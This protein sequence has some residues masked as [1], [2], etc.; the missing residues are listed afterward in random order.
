MGASRQEH[1]NKCCVP[2]CAA[3]TQHTLLCPR[4]SSV[5][6]RRLLQPLWS[7]PHRVLQC[8]LAPLTVGEVR[9]L[10][11]AELVAVLGLAGIHRL[12]IPVPTKEENGPRLKQWERDRRGGMC[13]GWRHVYSTGRLEQT[14][15]KRRVQ[16]AALWQ[17]P[18]NHT[19]KFRPLDRIRGQ[20]NSRLGQGAKIPRDHMDRVSKRVFY[21]D[22]SLFIKCNGQGEKQKQVCPLAPG[23]QSSLF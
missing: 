20:I 3:R 17:R 19:G 9:P 12:G 15:M 1:S 6:R 23:R 4:L 21:F 18:W 8:A 5:C 10:W 13:C 22:K 2:L 16:K 14:A 11:E 7:Q